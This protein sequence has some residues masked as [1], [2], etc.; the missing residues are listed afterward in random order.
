MV[1]VLDLPIA[2]RLTFLVWRKRG[3]GCERCGR[4]FPETDHELPTRQPAAEARMV[5]ASNDSQSVSRSSSASA[6]TSPGGKKAPVTPSST[7]SVA[8]PC[9][10]AATGRPAACAS[11]MAMPNSS[12]A[13]TTSARQPA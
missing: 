5:E 2:G 12:T 4:S 7:I 3:F 8:P 10:A 9:S 13:G 1:R 6:S 11:T